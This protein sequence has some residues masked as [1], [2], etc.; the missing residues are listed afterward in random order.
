[1]NTEIN[2]N[3]ILLESL[4]IT[5]DDMCV[6]ICGN[7]DTDSATMAADKIFEL[8]KK[9]LPF[10]PVVIHSSGGNVDD[11][12]TL[13]NVIDACTTPIM[14]ICLSCACSAAAVL[15][16]LGS[17]GMRIMAPNSY[18]MF[19]ESS[20]CAEGKQL[21]IATL[22]AHFMKIDRMI[23]RKIERH[24]DLETNFFENHSNDLYINARE[25]HKLNICN[26]VGFPV[27]KVNVSLE[28]TYDVKSNKRHEMLDLNRKAKYH[29]TL[30]GSVPTIINSAY[31]M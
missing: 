15:F 13:I 24:I 31:E 29:K 18:L 19:H 9:N 17:N 8:E 28:M 5:N 2:T 11:L 6:R 4:T 23:N 16:A 30:S 12:L 7:I 10:I 21:D 1:M 22:N 20:S 27:I 25:A 14:T 3:H 26:H